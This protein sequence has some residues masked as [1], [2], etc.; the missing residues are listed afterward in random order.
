MLTKRMSEVGHTNISTHASGW[1]VKILRY[2]FLYFL[3]LPALLYS[4]VFQYLQWFGILIA[5]QDFDFMK[6]I[7]GSSFVGF[8]HF[9]DVFSTPK[10]LFAIKNTL[11]YSSVNLIFGFPMPI[12]LA[13]LFNEMRSFAFKRFA[14]TVSY[15]PHFLSW[16][17]V[18]AMFTAFFALEGSFYQLRTFL[19]GPEVEKFNILT[20]PSNFVYILYFSNLWKAIGWN[21]IIYLAA[22]TSIDQQ[23]YEA[24]IIDGC[25]RF[26]QMWH[27]TLPGITQTIVIIL[28]LNM[29]TLVM[30][31]FEQVYSFQNVFNQEMTEVINT[32]T[33]R[34]GL[35]QGNYSSATAFGLSQGLVSFII[36]FFANKV[37]KKISGIGIW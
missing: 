35:L 33:Y 17:S 7:T 3:I 11:F 34:Q 25:G 30:S 23:I 22:I 18:A 37:S 15:I 19:F 29:G 27:V 16:V 26:K 36:V 32:L 24:A 13:L 8:K 2:K 4:L 5:F 6:G 9:I 10:F 20:E 31:N 1:L 12:I 28:V 14:Q 21:S